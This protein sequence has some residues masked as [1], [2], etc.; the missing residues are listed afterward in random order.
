MC[1][2]AIVFLNSIYMNIAEQGGRVPETKQKFKY[3]NFVSLSLFFSF[4]I[5]GLS[6]IILYIRPEGSIARWIG[7]SFWGLTKKE[8]EG[9]HTLFSL[10]VI[11]FVLFHILYN[12]KI[13]YLYLKDKLTQGWHLKR[14]VTLAFLVV[15]IF[16]IFSAQQWPPFSQI[17]TWRSIVKKSKFR[18]A[19][20]A[21]EPDF[22][23]KKLTEVSKS[24][25][26]SMQDLKQKLAQAKLSINHKAN[27]LYDIAKANNLSPEKVYELLVK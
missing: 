17:L 3:R 14:E 12:W 5:L 20:P 26:I 16:F 24:L 23:K 10:L 7:W 6:G 11:G 9:I 2:Q 1:A 8:W 4:I 21:P 19:I 18:I 25:D 15:T 13:L 27:S 22:E